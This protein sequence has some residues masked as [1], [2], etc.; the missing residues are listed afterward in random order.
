MIFNCLK[1]T[2]SNILY[3]KTSYLYSKSKTIK[4]RTA[5]IIRKYVYIILVTNCVRLMAFTIAKKAQ[6]VSPMSHRMEKTLRR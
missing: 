4:R 1:K 6:V 3:S 2:E 5:A